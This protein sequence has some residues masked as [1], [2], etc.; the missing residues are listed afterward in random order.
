MAG[1]IT[2]LAVVLVGLVF[3][4]VPAGA[5]TP[6]PYSSP[7]SDSPSA[8]FLTAAQV[9]GAL[10]YAEIYNSSELPVNMVGWKVAF[11]TSDG[12]LCEITLQDW[13]RPKSYGLVGERTI[14]SGDDNFLSFNI[15]DCGLAVTPA[16]YVNDIYLVEG[17][18]IRDRLLPGK[19]ENNEAW[20]R[21]NKTASCT[22]ALLRE[23]N[24]LSDFISADSWAKCREQ[25]YTGGWYIGPPPDV[26]GLQI[27]EVLAKSRKCSPVEVDLTC[28][29]YVKLYNP[30]GH[31]INL[32][33]YRLRIGYQG[34]SVSVTNT[35]TWGKE[36]M[37]ELEEY[38]LPSGEYFM[39]TVRNDGD[40]LSI[41]DGGGFVWLEDFYGAKIYSQTIVEYPDASSTTKEGWAWAFDGEGWQWTSAPQPYAPNYFPLPEPEPVI[42]T[43]A[44]VPCRPDQ[45]RNPDT[46]RCKLIASASSSLMPCKPSQQRNP[47]TNR[48]RSV[49]G[50]S[51]TLKPC[52]PGQERNPATNRCRK[53]VGTA[54]AAYAVEDVPTDL[55]SNMGW[56][57]AGAAGIGVVGYGTYEWRRE[58]LGLL[59]KAKGLFGK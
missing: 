39:L 20:V 16:T 49:A 37:P 12:E 35:F 27:L 42:P 44:L 10:D 46:N 38:I 11:S 55:S 7:S 17:D 52:G 29:D 13:L 26:D 14:I 5:A 47:A 18:V 43:S 57:L 58:L 3:N 45:F 33:D 22:S 40:L 34:Q 32:A 19:D 48:C 59:G 21:R 51:T 41:T 23:G 53:I 8:V 25:L 36:V 6:T 56:W 24:F 15:A 1:K 4:A 9:N 50:A 31:D 30:T 54:E 2:I 28:G